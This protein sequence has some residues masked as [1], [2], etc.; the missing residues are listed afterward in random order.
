[1]AW[2]KAFREWAGIGTGF[3]MSLETYGDM[4]GDPLK[5]PELTASATNS[6]L[7]NRL[8]HWQRSTRNWWPPSM[9]G[10]SSSTRRLQRGRLRAKP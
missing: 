2:V 7:Y 4:L 1:M 8:P 3:E 6:T 10:W 9:R 5:S